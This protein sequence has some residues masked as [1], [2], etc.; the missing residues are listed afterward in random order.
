MLGVLGHAPAPELRA[1]GRGQAL[2]RALLRDSRKQGTN[3]RLTVPTV[4]AQSPNGRQLSS[5]RPPCD[6]F[7]IYS[8]HCCD[9]GRRKQ[10]LS[11][12]GTCRHYDGLSSWT[13]SC[14]P[15]SDVFLAPFRACLGCPIWSSVTILPSPA[16]TMRPPGAGV[17]KRVPVAPAIL[18]HGARLRRHVTLALADSEQSYPPLADYRS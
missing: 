6:R 2:L 4:A 17:S 16:V 14:D 9:L 5:L 7:R 8:E 11:L 3:L 18:R 15:A 1:P 10:R 13:L 12:W